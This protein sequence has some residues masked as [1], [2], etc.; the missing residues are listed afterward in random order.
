MINILKYAQNSIDNML[1]CPQSY[2]PLH[3]EESNQF[4]KDSHRNKHVKV[5]ILSFDG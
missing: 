3:R 2:Y 1:S 5:D 4:S